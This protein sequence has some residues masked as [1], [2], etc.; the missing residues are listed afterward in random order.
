[1]LVGYEPRVVDIVGSVDCES[2][3]VDI[4]DWS[5]CDARCVVICY[6]VLCDDMDGR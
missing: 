6:A 1:M 5:G 2:S 4:V 3:V